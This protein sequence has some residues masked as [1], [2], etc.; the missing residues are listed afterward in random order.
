MCNKAIIEGHIYTVANS[1][2]TIRSDNVNPY[3]EKIRPGAF[4]KSIG[5]Y[6]KVPLYFNHERQIADEES[7]EIHEDDEGLFFRA[8]IG[9][10]EVISRCLFKQ[11][12]GCSFKY[13][14]LEE[15][16]K[17]GGIDNRTIEEM[18]LMEITVSDREPCY[19]SCV[20]IIYLPEEL[21]IKAYQYHVDD[22]SISMSGS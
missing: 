2:A 16:I 1:S 10:I 21:K 19:P 17:Y 7:I 18:F 22:L 11:M 3:I 4:S 15:L 12:K 8:N 9:D 14:A 5:V 13:K 20:E 6:G